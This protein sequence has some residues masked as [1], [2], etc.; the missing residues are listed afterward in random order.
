M[1]ENGHITPMGNTTHAYKRDYVEDTDTDVDIILK[2]KYYVKML[3][4]FNWLK[5]CFSGGILR[6]RL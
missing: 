1:K 4:G 5:M 2:Q 3:S 6:K